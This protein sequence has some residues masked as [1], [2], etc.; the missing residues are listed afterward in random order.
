M[1]FT[2]WNKSKLLPLGETTLN[3]M[4]P[5]N[6]EIKPVIYIVMPNGLMCLLSSKTCQEMGL[7]LINKKTSFI[8][9][10]EIN[11]EERHLGEFDA[12]KPA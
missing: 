1:K 8:A 5:K 4:N 7:V 9:N 10:V 12:V 11:D 2:M 6:G 3:V